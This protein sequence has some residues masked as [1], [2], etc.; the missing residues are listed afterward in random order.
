MYRCWPRL[1]AMF[2]PLMLPTLFEVPNLRTAQKDRKLQ[3]NA[4]MTMS[5]LPIS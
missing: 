3:K 5:A 4:K 2:C 1:Q